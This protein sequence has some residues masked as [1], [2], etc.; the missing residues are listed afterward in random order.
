MDFLQ[1]FDE[2]C[3]LAGTTS[4]AT[5][6]TL[7]MPKLQ[8]RYRESLLLGGEMITT[9]STVRNRL[10]NT[11]SRTTEMKQSGE[12][13]RAKARCK[14]CGKRGHSATQCRSKN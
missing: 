9:Y 7:I 10:L 1:E 14:A 8:T 3:L 12:Q 13:K 6:I 4:D 11:Y 5:K 2:L